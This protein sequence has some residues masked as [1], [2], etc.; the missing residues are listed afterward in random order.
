MWMSA[1]NG[2]VGFSTPDMISF[3]PLKSENGVPLPLLAPTGAGGTAFDADYAGAGSVFPAVN[4]I[5]LLLIYHAEN[6][7]FSSVHSNG[8]PFYAGIG[9]ARSTDGGLTWQREGQILSGHDS[10]QASQ[11]L[12]GAGIMT[13]AAIEANGYIYVFFRE[14]DLES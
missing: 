4:G 2:T 1:D 12:S 11:P 5:D 6:H 9:L 8:I 13:P 7:L 3:S 10:Q 14:I